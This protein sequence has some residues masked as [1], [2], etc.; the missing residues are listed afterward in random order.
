MTIIQKVSLL[1]LLLISPFAFS[2]DIK[3]GQIKN[4]IELGSFVGNRDLS[5][6]VKNIL[7]EV[8]QE[9]GYEINPNSK[10]VIEIELLYFDVKTKS[11]QLALY[12]NS[13]ESTEIIARAIL[14]TEDG[15]VKKVVVKG[16]AKSTS[17]STLIID[18]GGKFSQT[19]VSSAIK[20]MCE[21]I[22]EKLNL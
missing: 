15:S 20:K 13:D 18:K 6:G 1:I 7:E 21:K 12:G 9:K 14:S 22:I 2:Q 8:V 4:N 10:K 5:F 3:I 16:E 19:N 11:M 17:A